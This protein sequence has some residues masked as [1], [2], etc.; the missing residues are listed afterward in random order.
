MTVMTEQK[1]TET[2]SYH[3]IRMRCLPCDPVTQEKGSPGRPGTADWLTF[4]LG[5]LISQSG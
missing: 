2:S 3:R 4:R 5:L 1:K